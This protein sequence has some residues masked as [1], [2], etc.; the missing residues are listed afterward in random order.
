MK[1]RPFRSR[2]SPHGCF[3]GV[4]CPAPSWRW[5]L[6]PFLPGIGSTI[7]DTSAPSLI[8]AQPG[9]ARCEGCHGCHSRNGDASLGNL[10]RQLKCCIRALCWKIFAEI[11]STGVDKARRSCGCQSELR[12]EYTRPH[13]RPLDILSVGIVSLLGFLYGSTLPNSGPLYHASKSNPP[14]LNIT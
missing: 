2:M 7:S 5:K 4:T 6:A 14:C 3:R 13:Q 8:L 12:P 1:T 9:V 10:A 11:P